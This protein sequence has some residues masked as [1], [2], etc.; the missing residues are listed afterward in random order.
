MPCIKMSALYHKQLQRSLLVYSSY[1]SRHK[2]EWHNQQLQCSPS[3][4]KNYS[5]SQ[6]TPPYIALCGMEVRQ[7]DAGA[8]NHT[9]LINFHLMT[10]WLSLKSGCQPFWMNNAKL[11]TST[12]FIA[13]FCILQT[14]LWISIYDPTKL[15]CS[16]LHCQNAQS[17]ISTSFIAHFCILQ[18]CLWIS[19]Y[20]PTKLICETEHSELITI[21]FSSVWMPRILVNKASIQC[22]VNLFKSC[23]GWPKKANRHQ[24][25]PRCTMFKQKPKSTV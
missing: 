3:E 12:S 22:A 6:L 2:Y 21:D 15:M 9:S 8:I 4:K 16:T 25:D 11:N 20:D 7:S 13:H 1:S 19:I 5:S 18:T 23:D 14:C 24:S 17:R 10:E